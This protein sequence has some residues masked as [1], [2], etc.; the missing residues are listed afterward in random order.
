MEA[1]ADSSKNEYA[2]VLAEHR[3]NTKGGT[4]QARK[5]SLP[6]VLTSQVAVHGILDHDG[7][8]APPGFV[9]SLDMSDIMT[10][11][12]AGTFDDHLANRIME[13]FTDASG[14]TVYLPTPGIRI[15]VS[16]GDDKHDCD[17]PVMGFLSKPVNALILYDRGQGRCTR[18]EL[19]YL[20]DEY[21]RK[22][23]MEMYMTHPSFLSENGKTNHGSVSMR[24]VYARQYY[25]T[26][27]IQ[28]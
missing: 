15:S 14:R 24:E 11:S 10:R 1:F 17:W 21:Y 8:V 9:L 3:R 13:Q 22:L 2:I 16:L 18:K 25:A 28:K 27:A 6:P 23:P 4:M 5:R 26:N 19:E 12:F 20:V 7:L